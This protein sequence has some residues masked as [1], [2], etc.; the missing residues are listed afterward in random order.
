MLKLIFRP[1]RSFGNIIPWNKRIREVFTAIN[2]IIQILTDAGLIKTGVE[3]ETAVQPDSQTIEA[4]EP[5]TQTSDSA[6]TVTVTDE[7][8]EAPFDYQTSEDVEALLAYAVIIGAAI[9]GT[10][11]KLDTIKEKIKARLDAITE[12]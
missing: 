3:A 4:A 1:V 11:K 2:E 8:S 6:E 5:E 9:P 12:D 10:V 7:P